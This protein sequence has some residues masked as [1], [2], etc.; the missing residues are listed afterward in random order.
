MSVFPFSQTC[1]EDL[2]DGSNNSVLPALW[3]IGNTRIRLRAIDLVGKPLTSAVE[4]YTV[5]GCR[6]VEVYNPRVTR[7]SG[8]V[9]ALPQRVCQNGTAS[10]LGLSARDHAR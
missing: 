3:R 8:Y 4:L 6:A 7:G 10:G 9:G 5:E 2:L 1:R